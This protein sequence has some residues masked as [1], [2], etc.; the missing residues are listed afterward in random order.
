MKK[1]ISKSLVAAFL[2]LFGLSSNVAGMDSGLIK[3]PNN[4]DLTKIG[5]S[6]NSNKHGNDDNLIINPNN[7][8]LTKIGMS[9]GI[10]NKLSNKEFSMIDNP[11]NVD[12]T[13]IG[14]PGNNAIKPNNDKI[15]IPQ[16]TS[17]KFKKDFKPKEDFRKS[18]NDGEP[19]I[20]LDYP[21]NLLVV[22]DNED[23]MKKVTSLLCNNNLSLSLGDLK[24]LQDLNH[25]KS[26]GI[27]YAVNNPN[28]NVLCITLDDFINNSFNYDWDFICQNTT[29]IFY[30]FGWDSD[31]AE[32]YFDTLKKFYHKFN[33]HWCGK[34]FSYDDN[35]E[36]NG[37][38]VWGKNFNKMPLKK[39]RNDWFEYIRVKRG[40]DDHRYIF[41]LLDNNKIDCSFEFNEYV[42][43][44][45]DARSITICEL[46]DKLNVK[47]FTDLLF[48]QCY[49]GFQKV[50]PFIESKK[51]SNDRNLKSKI[52]TGTLVTAA[53]LG[54][55]GVAYK[56]YKKFKSK[57]QTSN[58][59]QQLEIKDKSIKQIDTK[60]VS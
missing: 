54:T 32:K 51:N 57:N 17:S 53:L 2:S 49:E 6:E 3:N 44:M 14:M 15:D 34:D 26:G 58:K 47:L 30:T 16:K 19:A 13:K 5:I 55:T 20:K 9:K 37:Y 22:A 18:Y 28:I 38:T 1:H 56:F 11:N 43:N 4:V 40:L 23:R 25:Y 39:G 59:N 33:K 46:N 12:L 41:F 27:Y 10:P 42:S 50:Q 36:P 8:D 21:F 35:Y 24:N 48:E 60:S 7:V 31:N 45:P 29:K 52:I